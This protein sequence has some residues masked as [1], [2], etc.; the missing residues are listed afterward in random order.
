MIFFLYFFVCYKKL[1]IFASRFGNVY[2]VFFDILAFYFALTEGVWK[3]LFG[4]VRFKKQGK[5]E[6][7]LFLCLRVS[8]CARLSGVEQQESASQRGGNVSG[9]SVKCV[10]ESGCVPFCLHGFN[11]TQVIKKT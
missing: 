9:Q 2:S 4:I 7:R 3:T 10:N 5:T 8:W 11:N 6:N 1:L